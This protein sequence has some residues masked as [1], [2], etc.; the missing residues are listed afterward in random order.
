MGPTSPP[1]L[2]LLRPLGAVHRA[3]AGSAAGLLLAL[4]TL[5]HLS[6]PGHCASAALRPRHHLGLPQPCG[7]RGH[8]CLGT[9]AQHL[10]LSQHQHGLKGFSGA[11]Q[12][13]V[14]PPDSPR[15]LWTPLLLELAPWQGERPYTVLRCLGGR[16]TQCQVPAPQEHEMPGHLVGHSNG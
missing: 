12:P 5:W 16:D 7:P 11:G 9:D 2:V 3:Q 1:S 14:C 15:G 8:L 10:S 13:S 6:Q 4:P